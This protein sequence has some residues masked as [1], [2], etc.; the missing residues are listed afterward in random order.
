MIFSS[1]HMNSVKLGVLASLMALGAVRS[2]VGQERHFSVR[3]EA[4]N[5][6]INPNLWGV[7]FEDINFGADGGIYAELIKNRSFEFFRPMMGWKIL[8]DTPEGA[9]MVLNREQTHETNPRFLRIDNAK[10]SGTVGLE[11]EGFRGMGIRKGEEYTF[12]LMYRQPTGTPTSCRIQLVDSVGNAIGESVFFLEN[13]DDDWQRISVGIRAKSTEAKARFVIWFD[14]NAA[15]DVDMLS[16]FP[17]ETWNN[18]PNGLRKDMVQV[19]ADMNPGFLRFP[20]GCIV[21]GFDLS[22]RYQWKNTVGPIED[23][24]MVVN[25]WNF[26]FA[27]RLTPDY[28]QTFGLGFFEYFQLAEDIGA[29]ALPII[30]CGMA[31]QYNTGEVVPIDQLGP[32]VQDALDLVEFANGDISTTWGKVRA[33]M[34][35]PEP[36]NLK[37]MGVG[38]ENW[39]PQYLERLAIFQKALKDRYPDIKVVASS[40]TDP[41]GE[42]FEY[43]DTNLRKMGVDLI[44]E[45][46][47]REPQW[48]LSNAARYDHYERNGPKIFAG[49]YAAHTKQKVKPEDKNNWEAALAEAAFL[50]GVERNADVVELASYAP[51]FAH[52]EGWQ[53]TPDLIWVDN[54]QVYLTPS[55]YVQKIFATNTGTHIASVQENGQN[56]TGQEGIYSSAVFNREDKELVIK[57]VNTNASQQSV[58]LDLSTF[59]KRLPKT[60]THTLLQESNILATNRV[61]EPE[62]I[63]PAVKDLRVEKNSLRVEALPKSLNVFKVKLT[64]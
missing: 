49:E 14:G 44:D 40:G 41:Q 18:R 43:L 58:V 48:F 60:V 34:G 42:R 56:L 11:N 7:F 59:K 9:V 26:E 4:E 36:F 13:T 45:H 32:Y 50:T 46:F 61:G 54:L 27:N 23:R 53:W 30:N 63:H 55:Y 22:Q 20:G 21:E 2:V 39:G 57:L 3:L 64:L 37:M 24:Q 25:R 28:F 29:E 62:T 8:G 33:E 19:L 5:R 47:Y 38:N 6:T 52:Y 1:L 15:V 10:I 35:H 51:L 17:V 31:C 16:L 12:S